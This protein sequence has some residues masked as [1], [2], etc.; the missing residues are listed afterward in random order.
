MPV[1]DGVLVE[2][3][4]RDNGRAIGTADGCGEAARCVGVVPGRCLEGV[5]MVVTAAASPRLPGEQQ[6][7]LLA[8]H[9]CHTEE[10]TNEI[11]T[12]GTLYN[13]RDPVIDLAER[14]HI[15]AR[16]H[17]QLEMG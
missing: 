14:Q 8:Q 17:T 12:G 2:G 16:A 13:M 5:A 6:R 7:L 9:E 11:P 1:A 15:A 3:D 4:L 10:G